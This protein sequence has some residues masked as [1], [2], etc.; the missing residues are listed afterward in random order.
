MRLFVTGAVIAGLSAHAEA[1]LAADAKSG[2]CD[3]LVGAWDYAPP[4]PPGS[5]VI[6]KQGEKYVGSFFMTATPPGAKTA[7]PS[8]KAGEA[9]ATA[10]GVWEFTCDG[11]RG[12]LRAK[13]RVLRSVNFDPVGS[14]S[15]ADLEVK[16]DQ[17]NWWF[18]GPD[19]KRGD[20]NSAKRA[21]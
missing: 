12:I 20:V 7:G 13:N 3:V 9:G 6:A 16:G 1:T 17:V 19:G 2:N 18:L 11:A 14:E 15:V 10:A 21:K 4:T 5:F 8:A